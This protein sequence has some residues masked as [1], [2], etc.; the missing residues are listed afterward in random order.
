M[1]LLSLLLFLSI[2]SLQKSTYL[3]SFLNFWEASAT[4]PYWGRV[5][6]KFENF[7]F[8]QAMRE[9]ASWKNERISKYCLSIFKDPTLPDKT[10]NIGY[11]YDNY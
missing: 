7:F 3:L 1:F 9:W 6:Y 4:P 11:F 5:K 10:S 8:N 2:N